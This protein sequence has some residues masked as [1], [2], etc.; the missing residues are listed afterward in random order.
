MAIPLQVAFSGVEPSAAVELRVREHVERLQR[1][2]GEVSSCQVTIAST[3]LP[4]D[5]DEPIYRV[6]IDLTVP[7]TGVGVRTDDRHPEYADVYVAL[8]DAFDGVL[9][10]IRRYELVQPDPQRHRQAAPL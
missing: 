3:A 10:L 5:S 1:F 8:R 2:H 4:Q 6:S 7:H 9:R